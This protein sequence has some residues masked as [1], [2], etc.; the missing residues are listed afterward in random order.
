MPPVQLK[1]CALCPAT[2]NQCCCSCAFPLRGPQG[3]AKHDQASDRLQVP[4]VVRCHR[5]L[6]W[7]HHLGKSDVCGTRLCSSSHLVVTSQRMFAVFWRISQLLSLRL[8]LSKARQRNA[9]R[10]CHLLCG[11]IVKVA[12]CAE[13]CGYSAPDVPLTWQPRTDPPSS[14]GCFCDWKN[15]NASERLP[16]SSPATSPPPPSL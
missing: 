2:I 8:N 7:R 6:S 12:T 4:P 11:P 15:I 10:R 13:I 1:E 16:H 5:A 9:R 3:L 14:P